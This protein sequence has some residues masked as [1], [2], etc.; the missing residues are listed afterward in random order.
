MD[1]KKLGGQKESFHFI[2]SISFNGFLKGQKMLEF[3]KSFCQIFWGKCKTLFYQRFLARKGGVCAV[4]LKWKQISDKRQFPRERDKSKL[5]TKGKILPKDDLE[6]PEINVS[7]KSIAAPFLV[8]HKVGAAAA[9][10]EEVLLI[11]F[12]LQTCIIHFCPDFP[13]V[14]STFLP[15]SLII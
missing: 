3:F 1:K 13:K 4:S 5:P 12:E 14:G 9:V 11:K 15:L 2:S 8:E 7:K 6:Y 10:E